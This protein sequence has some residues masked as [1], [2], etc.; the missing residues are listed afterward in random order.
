MTSSSFLK[1]KNW[2]YWIK[3]EIILGLVLLYVFLWGIS[4]LLITKPN[5]LDAFFLPAVKFG[6]SG[7]PLEIYSLRF[8]RS[9]KPYPNANGPLSLIPLTAV[10]LVA[11][12]LGWL[13]NFFL[14]RMLIL[15]AFAPF[16]I[17]MAR[18]AI[19]AIEKLRQTRIGKTQK[20]VGY[21]LILGSP[22]LW[23]GVL[24]YGHIELPILLWLTLL[25]IRKVKENRLGIAGILFGLAILDRSIAVLYLATMFLAIIF[26]KGLKKAVF[27]ILNAAVVSVLGIMP[28]LLADYNNLI[29]SLVAYRGILPVDKSSFWYH[30]SQISPLSAIQRFDTTLVISLAFL[31]T[32]VIIV[33][34]NLKPSNRDLFATL[35]VSSLSFPFLIKTTTWPYYF[36][37]SYIFIVIWWLGGLETG[38]GKTQQLGILLPVFLAFLSLLTQYSDYKV[39]S[40]NYYNYESAVMAILIASFILVTEIW[41]TT[42]KTSSPHP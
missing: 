26:Q 2:A 30:F 31:L 3:T 24:V 17:L 4:A 34:R 11:S 39:H 29:F 27:F 7:H 6:L 32:T 14:R 38:T 5:D 9:S 18:E 33:R 19:L 37:D 36:L 40:F 21:A 22:P 23:L 41:I 12:K 35:T 10:S 25:A 28:F 15:A 42:K 13:D 16:S 8:E 1:K 20:S